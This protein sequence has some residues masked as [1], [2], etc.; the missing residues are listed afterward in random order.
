M[1]V[2]SS[3]STTTAMWVGRSCSELPGK[4]DTSLAASPMPSTYPGMAPRRPVAV[5]AMIRVGTSALPSERA[6]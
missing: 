5:C 2:V 3:K 1:P 6:A 4:T